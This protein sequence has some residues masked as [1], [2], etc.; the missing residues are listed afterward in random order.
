M[1]GL[2]EHVLRAA[3]LAAHACHWESLPLTEVP[4]AAVSDSDTEYWSDEMYINGLI[5]ELAQAC[6]TTHEATVP[7]LSRVE[8]DLLEAVWQE[9]RDDTVW[10]IPLGVKL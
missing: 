10:Q 9:V 8:S 4:S 3:R 6:A 2:V 5:R 7:D 1:A